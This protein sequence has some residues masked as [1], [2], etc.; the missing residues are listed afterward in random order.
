MAIIESAASG[1]RGEDSGHSREVGVHKMAV[2]LH[3]GWPPEKYL[4]ISVG[5]LYG[6]GFYFPG[7]LAGYP[8][9]ATSVLY[10][11]IRLSV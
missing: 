4:H 10:R 5:T 3:L 11:Y 2:T 8:L 1:G 6:D 9:I 7:Q